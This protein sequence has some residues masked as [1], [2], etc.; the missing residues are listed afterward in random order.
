[1]RTI[2]RALRTLRENLR[3]IGI[4]VNAAREFSE[5][6]KARSEAPASSAIPL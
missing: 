5:A 3:H 6:G 2:F 4:A 1:M